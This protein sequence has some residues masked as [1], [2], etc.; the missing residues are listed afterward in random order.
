MLYDSNDVTLDGAKKLSFNE[1]IKASL[2]ETISAD[3]RTIT[4]VSDGNGYMYITA[5]GKEAEGK[6]KNQTVY[7]IKNTKCPAILTEN[8]FYDNIIAY[9]DITELPIRQRNA[10]SHKGSYGKVLLIAGFEEM[11]GACCMAAEAAYR[12]GAGLVRVLTSEDA[13]DA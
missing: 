3:G 9:E 5:E 8:F 1:N 4:Y 11:S 7:I 13:K 2:K 10:D 6:S 12:C